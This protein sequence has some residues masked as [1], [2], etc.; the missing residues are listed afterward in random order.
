M[1]MQIGELN[2]GALPPQFQN[3]KS[4]F[5]RGNSIRY[6]I[7]DKEEVGQ[8]NIDRLTQQCMEYNQT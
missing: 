7:F 3:L 6:V 1:N 2:Q 8:E 5:I 4:M